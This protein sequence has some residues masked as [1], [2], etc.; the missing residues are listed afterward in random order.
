[1]CCASPSRRLLRKLDPQN[2][3]VITK[4]IHLRTG[5]GRIPPLRK[6]HKRKPL[7]ASRLS[8][9][10]QKHPRH[11]SPPSEQIPQLVLLSILAHV[12]HAQC[13][14][15]ITFMLPH[16]PLAAATGTCAHRRREVFARLAATGG[17]RAGALVKRIGDRAVRRGRLP[18]RSHG[19]LERTSRSEVFALANPTF[20]AG[21]RQRRSLLLLQ[22][23]H[24][25]LHVSLAFPR[26]C[27][28]TLEPHPQI[29]LDVLA[30]G[31]GIALRA[32]RILG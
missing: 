21:R 27:I 22:G 6:T 19:A 30:H 16:H 17:A 23:L 12:G 29:Q 18:F 11:P 7:G 25:L 13:R 4:P 24:F 14:Q 32:G 2:Q 26:S 3:I 15:V 8:V 5:L 10:G 28:P 20:Y 31:R 9:L 1:M